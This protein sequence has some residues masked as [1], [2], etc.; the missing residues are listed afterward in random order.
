M[1]CA[2]VLLAVLTA[3]LYGTGAALEHRQAARTPADAAGRPASSC[4]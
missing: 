3:L 2:S 4:C 1:A